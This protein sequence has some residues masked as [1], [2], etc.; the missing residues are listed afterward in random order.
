[1]NGTLTA[2]GQVVTAPIVPDKIAQP[3]AAGGNVSFA[4]LTVS[5]H[6]Y[7]VQGNVDLTT[8]NWNSISNFTGDG[9]VKTLT[10]PITNGANFYRVSQP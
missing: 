1:L 10:L 7:T 9:Y 6:S 5:N 4:F 8:A 3:L 2:T